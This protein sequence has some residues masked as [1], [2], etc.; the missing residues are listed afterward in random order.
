MAND[1]K[2]KLPTKNEA[3]MYEVAGAIRDIDTRLW[4]V[5]SHVLALGAIL[6]VDPAKIAELL[7]G[8]DAKIKE[9]AQKVNDEIQ[10]IN[11]VNNPASAVKTETEAE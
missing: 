2:K 4:S 8:D 1:F 10:K 9:Y 5:S 3:L 11:A 7:T 6:N